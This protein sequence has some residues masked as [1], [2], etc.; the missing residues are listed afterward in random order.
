MVVIAVH[1][2]VDYIPEAIDDESVTSEV[3]SF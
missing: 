1:H 2:D 3:I